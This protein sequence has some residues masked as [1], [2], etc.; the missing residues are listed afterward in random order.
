MISTIASIITALATLS[1]AVVAW[2]ALRTWRKEFIGKKKIDLACQIMESV[3][4]IQDLLW[5]A[6]KPH[7][8]SSDLEWV[9]L[10]KEKHGFGED[11]EVHE[12]KLH[13]LLPLYIFHTNMEAT[14]GL[15]MSQ[16]KAQLYWDDNITELF[17]ELR[18]CLWR[19]KEASKELYN[20][21]VPEEEHRLLDLIWDKGKDDKMSQRVE[22]IIAEFKLNLEPVYESQRTKWKKL[23]RK[24]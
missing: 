9:K 23:E 8:T 2:R 19:V 4:D 3:Y 7:R 14:E 16:N 21:R 15:S 6:R 10:Q 17:D 1:M 22:D 12:N 5:F 13:Y 24:R 11:T 18:G 20:S